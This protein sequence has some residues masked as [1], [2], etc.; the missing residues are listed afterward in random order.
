MSVRISQK[1]GMFSESVIREMTR[2]FL[3]RGDKPGV[4]LAQGFP[5]FPAPAAMK[6]AASR[7]IHAD[8][9]QYAITWGSKSLRNAIAEKV[10]KFSGFYPDPEREITVAC[11][12]T[13]AMMAAMLAVV[14]PGDEVI[15]FEPFYENYG[16]DA[17]LSGAQ[18]RFVTLH[19][20]DW[21]FDEAELSAAFNNKTR[22]IIIN[23]PNNPTG[24]VFNRAELEFIGALCQKWN[25]VAITDEIYEHMVYE[26]EHISL[27]T[28]PGM[29]EHTITISGLSKTYSATG[30]RIGWL[31]APP[32]ISAAIR[33]VHDF[34]TVGAAAPLQE[35]AATALAFPDSYYHDLQ[36][37]YLEKRNKMVGIL[38][39]AGFEVYK[40]NG[41]YYIMTDI[42][43]FGFPDDMTF[44]RY[45]VDKIGVG[46]VPGSSFYR[47]PEF[48][49]SKVRF[50]FCKKPET[51]DLAAELL[52]KLQPR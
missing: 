35:G 12:A 27:A 24:K 14:D 20:P 44:A 1:A 37:M 22:A 48:G 26:G 25:V 19:E 40:P 32:H 47:H 29:Y 15:V 52:S 21:H 30:W 8:I 4:N 36:K 9:N 17:I 23:T 33:K 49:K 11:G 16:P 7:A 18:P 13:E 28:L 43:R 10:A 38:E 2:I 6:E 39:K 42:S 41:A 5:D 51:L 45:L 34:L 46:S 31:I 3:A 50:T